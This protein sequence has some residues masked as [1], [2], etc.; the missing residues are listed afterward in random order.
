[1]HTREISE[2]GGVVNVM[3]KYAVMFMVFTLGSLGLPGTSGFVGE[4]LVLIGSFKYNYWI[5]FFAAIGVVL[6]ACYS[7]WLYRRVVF[8]NINNLKI[9]KLTDL[10]IREYFILTPLLIMTIVLGFYPALILDLISS[11]VDKVSTN[12]LNYIKV[13]NSIK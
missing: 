6:S 13:A 1:M 12:M 3:P 2:Y 10:N 5:A 11:S 4:I 8:G 9:E 7:L